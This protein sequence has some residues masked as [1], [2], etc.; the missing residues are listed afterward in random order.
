MSN[1]QINKLKIGIKNGTEVTLKISSNDVGDSND[2]NNFLHKLLLTNTQ[3]SKL[4]KA[5]VNGSPANI[6]L[7]KTQLHKRGQ[8]RRFL[9]RILG[10]L[11]ETKLHLIGNV[12][13]QLA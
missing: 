2:E 11:L 9:G 4:R 7:S 3:V 8:S 6:T 1:S 12:L 5:I 13:K 10:P